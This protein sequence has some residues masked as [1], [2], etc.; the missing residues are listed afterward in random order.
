MGV[1]DL[2]EP[3]AMSKGLLE[4]IAVLAAAESIAIDL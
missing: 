3:Q 2:N 4:N 1:K